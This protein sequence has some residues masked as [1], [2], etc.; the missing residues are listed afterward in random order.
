MNGKNKIMETNKIIEHYMLLVE[1]ISEKLEK[2][3]QEVNRLTSLLEEV[4]HFTF[5][6]DIYQPINNMIKKEL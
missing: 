2:E 5:D 6:K 1:L 3:E 4:E